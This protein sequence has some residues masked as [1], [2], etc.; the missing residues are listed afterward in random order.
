MRTVDAAVLEAM[1]RNPHTLPPGL[2]WDLF[3]GGAKYVPYQPAYHPFSWRGW[4]DFGTGALGDM[5]AHL[6]D[7]PY[8][9]LGLT[10]PVSVTS[11]S[12]PWGGMPFE[13]ASYPLATTVHY[14][15]AAR[16]AQPAVGV[17]WYDGSL[18]PPR[19]PF[20]P[21]D[22]PFPNAGTGGGIFVGDKGIITYATYGDNPTVYPES[23]AAAAAAVPTSV[24]RITVPHEVNFAQA[25]RGEA[26]ASCPFEYASALTETMLL[27][28]VALNAGEGAKIV[29][30]AS[31][32]KVVNNADASAYLTREYRKGWEI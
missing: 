10:Q 1:A 19:P 9:A 12:T 7:Q 16:G 17:H 3:L 8:W 26:T 28:I 18:L 31:A 29:Y 30:D 32:M 21:D 23:A 22:M 2:D 15:F 13:K 4:V 5:G 27:G 11:S 14:E 20:I 24:P 25:C 6:L